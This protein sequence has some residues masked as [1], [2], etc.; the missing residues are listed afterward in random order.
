MAQRELNPPSAH[1]IIPE[2]LFVINPFVPN[3]PFL[4]LLKTE[5]RKVF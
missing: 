5:N 2:R 3:A 1:V 4:Y